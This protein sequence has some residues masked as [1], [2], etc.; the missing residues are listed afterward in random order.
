[1]NRKNIPSVWKTE[2]TSVVWYGKSLPLR[3]AKIVYIFLITV[4][5]RL[6]L[7]LIP[8]SIVS[9]HFSYN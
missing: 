9:V 1:M 4:A 2:R 6:F 8:I 3:E 7:N 5:V